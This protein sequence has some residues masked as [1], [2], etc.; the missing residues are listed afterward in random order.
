MGW[1]LASQ[2]GGGNLGNRYGGDEQ[3]AR[4]LTEVQAGD[5][6]AAP[7]SSGLGSKFLQDLEAEK[8]NLRAADSDPRDIRGE[9]VLPPPNKAASRTAI[10][11]NAADRTG[12]D[13]TG[14]DR[15]ASDRTNINRGSADRGAAAASDTPRTSPLRSLP[16]AAE[17]SDPTLNAT[18]VDAVEMLSAA[19]AMPNANVLPG[20]PVTLTVALG[21]R[22][23]REGR[24]KIAH[25][26]WKL[27]AAAASHGFAVAEHARLADLPKPERVSDA[28]ID[29]DLWLSARA[30]A[31]ARVHETQI[32]AI[33]A[34]RELAEA[35]GAAAND[36]LPVVNDRPYLG[37][38]ATRFDE[39]FTTRAA[40][41][42]LRTIH[43]TLPALQKAVTQRAEAAQTAQSALYRSEDRYSNGK[44]GI[45]T[46]LS[47][48]SYMSQQRQA[49]I[50]VA[51]AYNDEIADYA[52]SVARDN[53][54]PAE[55]AGMMIR[56]R[57]TEQA[58]QQPPVRSADARGAASWQA[59]LRQPVLGQDSVGQPAGAFNPPTNENALRPGATFSG[60]SGW[61]QRQ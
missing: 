3:P 20:E 55:L 21:R 37:S 41:V 30:T 7:R 8:N 38:Y 31:Q 33:T 29:H 46:Y 19:F 54:A 2:L 58:R 44:Y 52:V 61:S 32:V 48:F 18:K 56:L 24:L 60:G 45:S 9:E 5:E 34:Q 35:M 23:D 53:A 14:N 50:A 42:R 17:A 11:R 6:P 59:P 39:L 13:R 40:P 36:P 27:S 57:P 25:A 43:E 26:F 51:R 10:D 4:R 47:Q 15:S 12:N 49:F 28:A 16:K 22:S 1:I